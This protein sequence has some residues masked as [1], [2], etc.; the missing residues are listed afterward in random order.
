[1]KRYERTLETLEDSCRIKGVIIFNLN[2]CG[3]WQNEVPQIIISHY[4]KFDAKFNV[5]NKIING[6]RLVYYI[7]CFHGFLKKRYLLK[8]V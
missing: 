4:L 3:G 6:Y 7:G 5:S 1:M 8:N 2:L